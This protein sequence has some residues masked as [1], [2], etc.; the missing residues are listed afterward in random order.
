MLFQTMIT[1][2]HFLYF[3]PN[4]PEM[5]FSFIFIFE[6]LLHFSFTQCERQIGNVFIIYSYL[7]LFIILSVQSFLFLF[8]Y[9]LFY[10]IFYFLF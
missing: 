6:K 5:K 9:F 3:D 1:N 2:I 8:F 4:G 10:F 7:L